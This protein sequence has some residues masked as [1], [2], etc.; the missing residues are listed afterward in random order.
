MY[1]LDNQQ[2]N[3]LINLLNSPYSKDS[4]LNYLL[5]SSP[6]SDTIISLAINCVDSLPDANLELVLAVNSPLS[7]TSWQYLDARS[8]AFDEQS[9]QRIFSLQG[10]NSP[11]ETMTMLEKNIKSF[12]NNYYLELNDY[13]RRLSK[14]DS[15]L[16]MIDFLKTSGT[17]YNLEQAFSIYLS[18]EELDS[19]NVLFEQISIR[20]D[21]E[22]DWLT[23]NGILLD[24]S[25]QEKSIF[26]MDSI[27]LSNIE[28]IAFQEEESP[29]KANAESILT[30][31]TWVD[32]EYSLP[33]ENGNRLNGSSY[34]TSNNSKFELLKIAP[35]PANNEVI[36]SGYSNSIQSLEIRDIMGKTVYLE[37]IQSVSG[38][39]KIN[40]TK[41]YSGS[42]FVR[43]IDNNNQI[44]LGKFVVA[45]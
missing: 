20:E 35:N 15:I 4:L 23:L 8:P 16:V 37:I 41:F 22:S 32:F 25:N 5:N 33:E 43:I 36:I 44:K 40:V 14:Q 13:F 26:E 2:Q 17:T 24:L 30:L 42:Y 29:S 9:Y 31:L 21:V 1:N 27:Q 11:Y 12:W 7:T 39:M 28:E 6:L 10:Y 34:G 3:A 18:N 45:R 38:M 19:A